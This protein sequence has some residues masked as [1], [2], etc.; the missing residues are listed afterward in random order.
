MPG[1]SATGLARGAGRVSQLIAM[2]VDLEDDPE[3]ILDIDHPVR[4]IVVTYWKI[5]KQALKTLPEFWTMD[6]S[7]SFKDLVLIQV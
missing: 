4:L 7:L 2:A 6:Y 5:Q 3:G 1:R